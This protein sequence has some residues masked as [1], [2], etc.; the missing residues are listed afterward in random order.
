VKHLDEKS[1]YSLGKWIRRKWFSCIEKH[2]EAE[3][4]LEK[5]GV[6]LDVL[7]TAWAEQVQVQTR[8]TASK[9]SLAYTHC[10]R[11]P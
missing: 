8:P 4:Q 11:S 10:R 7:K 1:L 5:L 2:S 9:R 3:A 6:E